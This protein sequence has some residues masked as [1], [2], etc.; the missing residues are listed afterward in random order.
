MFFRG[1]STLSLDAK[2]R[3]VM[4]SR[5]RDLLSENQVTQ[6]VVSI[7]MQG[8]KL[9]LYPFEQWKAFE[10]RLM[11]MPSLNEAVQRLQN[12]IIGN[13]F[14]VEPD[15]NGRISIPS[16]LREMVGLGK[17]ITMVGQG[18]RLEIWT[19]ESWEEQCQTWQQTGPVSMDELPDSVKDMVLF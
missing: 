8:K 6:L 16:Q 5:F 7:D 12:M 15:N 3:L 19:H 18:S 13:A 1:H 11:S 14:E 9:T 10:Q 2:G 17:K 4:P